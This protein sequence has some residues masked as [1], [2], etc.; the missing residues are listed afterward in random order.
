MLALYHGLIRRRVAETLGQ[1]LLMGAM[2]VGGMWVIVDPTG[3]VGALG[4]WANQASLGTL[5]VAARGT[6]AGAG[7]ALG[8][9]MDTRLRRR[10]RSAVVLPGVRRRR[11]VP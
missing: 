2:M 11:L 5:A 7:R 4:E 9:S 3:T 8:D 10:D 6:P 1:A